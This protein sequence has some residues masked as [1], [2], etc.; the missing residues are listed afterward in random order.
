M[1]LQEFKN[2]HKSFKQTVS[3]SDVEKCFLFWIFRHFSDFL[4]QLGERWPT[5]R[6]L[7]KKTQKKKKEVLTV[8]FTKT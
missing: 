8:I 4:Q 3:C 2:M 7:K 6:F 5:L 1:Y